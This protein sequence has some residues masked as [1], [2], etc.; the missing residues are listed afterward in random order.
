MPNQ[1]V[2]LFFIVC[3]VLFG[4]NLFLPSVSYSQQGGG[5]VI[6]SGN[7]SFTQVPA[8]F[9]FS[10]PVTTS[11]SFIQSETYSYLNTISG[12]PDDVDT[13]LVVEDLRDGGDFRIDV[14]LSSFVNENGDSIDGQIGTN[15]GEQLFIG[16]HAPGNTADW[17]TVSGVGYDPANSGPQNVV[18]ALDMGANLPNDI[19]NFGTSLE[20]PVTILEAPGP[21]YIGEFAVA[22]SYAVEIPILTKPGIYVATLEITAFETGSSDLDPDIFDAGDDI[23]AEGTLLLPPTGTQRDWGYQTLSTTDT[24]DW[25]KI[26]LVGG[27]TLNLSTTTTVGTVTAE[28]C[29]DDACASPVAGNTP[30]STGRYYIRVTENSGGN[31]RY[32]LN[33]GYTAQPADDFDTLDDV[34]ANATVIT[35]GLTEQSHGLHTLSATDT[36]DWF[37]FTA[38]NA[39][40]YN[41]NT[42]I[43]SGLTQI[44]VF[45]SCGG[46]SI[47]SDFGAGGSATDGSYAYLTVEDLLSSDYFIKVDSVIPSAEASY[48]LYFT[49]AF[50][51]TGESS[52]DVYDH[53]P[54]GDDR[55]LATP[56]ALTITGV[57]QS[58]TGHTLT[59]S[60]RNDIYEFTTTSGNTYNFSSTN[61]FGDLSIEILD[62]GF[63]TVETSVNVSGDFNHDFVAPA[64][65]TYYALV[66]YNSNSDSEI[67]GY[68]LVY[69]DNGAGVIDSNEPDN[70]GAEATLVDPSGEGGISSPHSLTTG[71]DTE[72][73]FSFNLTAGN[74]YTFSTSSASG[75]PLCYLYS[76]VDGLFQEN[77]E[78]NDDNAAGGNDCQTIFTAP[79][80]QTYYYRIV[81]SGGGDAVY[82]F[83]YTQTGTANS[84]DT[85]D[86]GDD[87]GAGATAL[88][89]PTPAIGLHDAHTL[90][91]LDNADWYSVTLTADDTY[92]FSSTTYSGFTL[93][94]LYSDSG[95]V[96]LVASDFNM[97]RGDGFS[98][99]YTAAAT[100]TYYLK[101]SEGSAG[102]ADYDLHYA[103]ISTDPGGNDLADPL[104]NSL[105]LTP[106]NLGA[107]LSSLGTDSG[108]TLSDDDMYDIYAFDLV[109]G[110]TY[111]FDS[112]GGTGDTYAD[113]LDAFGG[114]T[115]SDDN[116]GGSGMFDLS[117]L[118]PGTD[119]F[120]LRVRT[121]PVGGNA[122]YDLNYQCTAGCSDAFDPGDDSGAG[123]NYLGAPTT[124]LQSHGTHSL[125]ATDTEDWY[126]FDLTSGETYNFNSIVDSGVLVAE[127]YS[128]SGGVTLVAS[129]GAS[130]GADEF[131]LD[132]TAGATQTYYLK[133]TEQSGGNAT[134]DLNYIDLSTGAVEDGFDPSDNSLLL[135]PTALGTPTNS[136]G[137]S[138][139][140]TLSSTDVFDWYTVDLTSGNTYSFDSVGG[141][142]DTYADL[143]DPFGSLVA[144]DDNTGGGGMFDFGH[145]AAT[146]GTF[147]LRV[148]T[149]N[150]F[151]GSASY[152]LNYVCSSGCSGDAYDPG[153]DT[154]LGATALTPTTTPQ[155]HTTHTLDGT[156]LYDWYAVS[157]TSGAE[158]T[159]TTISGGDTTCELYE[160]I[161]GSGNGV[162]QLNNSGSDDDAGDGLNCSTTYTAGATQTYYYRVHG[163]TLGDSISY[164]FSYVE[165]SALDAYDPGDDTGAGATAITPTT[166]D[167]FHT[168]HLLSAT[169]TQDV[170]VASLTA[171][172]SY[173]FNTIG[174]ASGD[175]LISI[176]DDVALSNLVAEDP[177]FDQTPNASNGSHYDANLNFTASSTAN[178]YIVVSTDIPGDTADYSLNYQEIPGGELDAAD[179]VDDSAFLTGFDATN[180]GTPTLGGGTDSSH[181]LSDNDLYDWYSFDLVSGNTY[182][183][184]A[185]GGSGDNYASL[186]SD[187][188]GTTEVAFD[189]DSGGNTM[190]S[191]TYVAGATQT[192]YLRVRKFSLAGSSLYDLNYSQQ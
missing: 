15:G 153:D 156:D 54:S 90:S 31:A 129:D 94:E 151:G 37:R 21:S 72:D 101:I 139:T 131:S 46:A 106:T 102:N 91:P 76:D 140:H 183:F 127:L 12:L 185:I 189:D 47:G 176:Y 73:W 2:K 23:G 41:F 163:F 52:D 51:G 89:A 22:L 115:A 167:Q 171:G 170:F 20:S 122:S 87:T 7:F 93:A 19:A 42:I 125:S 142:G 133:I 178:Y 160:S 16:T 190:F 64:S 75:D 43:S 8:N 134:Y 9:V 78:S 98:L 180:L 96:T 88:G 120:Y 144:S 59:P 168:S 186:Y 107:P 11:S 136:V 114:I 30:G 18:A 132:Y 44:E 184:N 182:N 17:T 80:T 38:S 48:Q 32:Q 146:T 165:N 60:D 161:D 79:A 155:L 119:T 84:P 81:E 34:C 58:H 148:R 159:F 63:G 99:D 152:D 108:H 166:T 123:A 83:I 130:S 74:E 3:S 77:D 113:L 35:P 97:S 177:G 56:T 33:Y 116:T 6:T 86:P 26:D 45:D 4:A 28:L 157:L 175:T 95:G 66:S 104:D 110:N 154:G 111:E 24:E 39:E 172:T 10:N 65:A 150:N 25:F 118:A 121:S 71:T 191:L 162:N 103:D 85:Q 192:Y 40:S 188:T 135:S 173:N 13:L 55:G 187:A 50:A 36:E 126:S 61:S 105:L 67:A 169:D 143:F 181:T 14:Q 109:S 124:T 100:Q 29:N 138:N 112:I 141:S 1:K 70:S 149:A 179:P 82:D 53:T 128:D 62:S 27:E 92:N 69:I 57:S 49:N 174:A 145:T 117:V 164:D 137:S 5:Q 68:D 158:Y 147:S